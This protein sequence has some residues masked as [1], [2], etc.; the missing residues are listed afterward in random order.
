MRRGRESGR[1]TR[2]D[3]SQLR[4]EAVF[5]LEKNGT[6]TGI[7]PAHKAASE[8]AATMAL[9]AGEGDGIKRDV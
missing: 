9:E 4:G 8:R 7:Y 1:S 5:F 3:N 6:V 2:G